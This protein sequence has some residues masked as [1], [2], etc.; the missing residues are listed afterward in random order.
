MSALPKP[1]LTPEQY[2]AMERASDTRHE[3]F[4]GEVFAM[5]GTKFNHGLIVWN[6]SRMLGNQLID[7]PCFAVAESLRVKVKANG[8]YTYPDVVVSC[9]PPIFE[10][11]T[12]DTLLNPNL[13]I[14]VLSESTEAY[15]RGKK[16]LLY[17]GLPSLQ[18][19]VLIAQEEARIELFRLTDTGWN[20]QY[21]LGLT[22][23]ATL[24]S[25]NCVLP[26]TDVYHK[27]SFD[28]P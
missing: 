10:D 22:A 2:L 1:Y 20:I 13:I 7:R 11:N 12:P 23:V 16:F 3:Y 5:A 8:L 18:E 9:E 27:I 21:A 6:L 24:T 25:I 19:Y 26:L 15:D 4:R 14:E 17:Q 28:Q